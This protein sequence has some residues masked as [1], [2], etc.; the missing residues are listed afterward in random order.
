MTK[1]HKELKNKHPNL[2][3][4]VVGSGPSLNHI[5]KTFFNNKI[6]MG[7]NRV[8][9]SVRCD[10][11]VSKDA[12]G[13]KELVTHTGDAKIIISRGNCGQLDSLNKPSFD[14]YIFDH[15]PFGLGLSPNL[16][17]VGS[18]SIVISHSTITSAIHLAAY[19]GAKNIILVGH[20]CGSIDGEFIVKNYYDE[21]LPTQGSLKGYHKWLINDIE[22]HTIDLKNKLIEHYN[23]NIVSINPF[24]NLGMEG[25]L[26]RK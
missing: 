16:N 20:D 2:D 9:K 6:V 24:I 8:V 15:L 7:V 26:Y 12:R 5:N 21:I 19:M 18:D 25:H 11:V 22:K 1:S 17:A 10:Y 14:C 3:I 4:Y 23:C 13:F